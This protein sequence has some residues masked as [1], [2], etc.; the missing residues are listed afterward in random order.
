MMAMIP[1]RARAMPRPRNAGTA[2]GSSLWTI[3]T[4]GNRR[5]T[6]AAVPSVEL[7]ARI[8]SIP[9]DAACASSASRHVSITCAA[10]CPAMTTERSMSGIDQ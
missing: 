1:P 9:G 10:L 2:S 3:R 7:S 8:T 6:I 4:H 5:A